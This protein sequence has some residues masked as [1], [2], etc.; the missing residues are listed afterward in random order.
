MYGVYS[1]PERRVFDPRSSRPT[2]M[3]T[4]QLRLVAAV[5]FLITLMFLLIHQS[6]RLQYRPI[7]FTHPSL[8]LSFK[9]TP[10]GPSTSDGDGNDRV[11]GAPPDN[12]V[13]LPVPYLVEDDTPDGASDEALSNVKKSESKERSEPI[14]L[15]L[16]GQ[17]DTHSEDYVDETSNRQ[18]STGVAQ[19]FGHEDDWSQF[20]YAQY[21]TDGE[22]LCNSVMIF[23]ALN[24]LGSKPDRILVY[25]S[26]MLHDPSAPYDDDLK[27]E[28]RL[29]MQARDEYGVKLL[30]IDVAYSKIFHLPMVY[31]GSLEANLL[32]S[33]LV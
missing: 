19:I 32:P 30:P 28:A 26:Y 6:P 11:I 29:L 16:T 15:S 8:S 12:N 22:Y 1:Q 7:S 10:A 9:K 5:L 13:E 4:R 33:C 20:A 23:E 3:M 24:R 14:Q 25:P 17:D 18:F 2:A 31:P 27:G 21:V